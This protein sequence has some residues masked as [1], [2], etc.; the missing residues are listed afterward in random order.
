M[1]DSLLAGARPFDRR[2]FLKFACAGGLTVAVNRLP[3]A[4]AA[5]K[6]IR[7]PGKPYMKLSLAAYSFNT[8]LDLAKNPTMTLD[9]F[10]RYCAEIDLDATELTSYYFPRDFGEDYLIHLKELTFRLGLDISGTAIGN[11]FCFPPGPKRDENLALT[12]KWIDHSAFLGAP[13]IRIFGGYQR[14]AGGADEDTAIQRVADGINESL[15][16]AAKRGVFLGLENHG[17]I[18]ETPEQMLKIMAKVKD[19]P[20]FGV[21]FDGGGFT[22]DDPYAQLALIAPYAVN[23]QVKVNVTRGGRENGKSEE[24][25]LARVVKVLADAGYRGYIALEGGGR[26]PDPKAGIRGYIERLRQIIRNV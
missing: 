18:T 13:V 17:G 11:D 16:Y 19:S 20:W 4:A 10:I 1:P 15:D 5:A 22:G 24:A 3:G 2:R 8:Q 14:N 9:D 26:G 25:D 7:R 23:V 21:N 6:P 12:R